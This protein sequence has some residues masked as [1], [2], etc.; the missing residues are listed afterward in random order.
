[1]TGFIK[2][3]QIAAAVLALVIVGAA[4][5]SAGCGSQANANG[6][7]MQLGEADNGKSVTLK[8]GDSIQIKV[9]GNPTTGFEWTAALEAKDAALL[10]QQ[11]DP[12]YAD[13]STNPSI[14]GSGGTYT[15]TFKALAAGTAT[16]KLVYQRG[17]EKVE[18]AKTFTVTVTVQ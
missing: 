3:K 13:S 7:P 2:R 10:A 8:A 5:V 18:P 15:F 11:G 14:V 12:A 4:L 1:M 6:G 16:I 9:D 17:W